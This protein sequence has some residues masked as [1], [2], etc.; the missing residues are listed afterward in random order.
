MT[1]F[2]TLVVLVAALVLRRRRVA[3]LFALLL[4]ARFALAGLAFRREVLGFLPV[5]R[6][7]VRAAGLAVLPERGF[8]LFILAATP[9]AGVGFSLTP[10]RLRG[11]PE[12][13][14]GNLPLPERKCSRPQTH[15]VVPGGCVRGG[16]GFKVIGGRAD[17]QDSE[18]IGETNSAAKQRLAET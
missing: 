9:S 4:L 1:R 8:F 2:L 5:A 6:R 10:L 12:R 16:S 13:R 3:G 7:T 17:R 18:D 11:R 15:A 14:N